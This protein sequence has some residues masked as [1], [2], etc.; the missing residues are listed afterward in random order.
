M[1]LFRGEDG[2]LL[3]VGKSRNLR[4]RVLAHFSASH[5]SSKESKLAQQV[6]DVE[7]IETG[8]ELGALLAESRLVKELAPAANRRLRKPKGVHCIRL[9]DSEGR[10]KPCVEPFGLDDLESGADSYGPFRTERDAL[11]A[12]EGKA[13]E[14]GLCLKVM[15][16]ESG[17]G[18]CFALQLGRCRGACVGTESP[19]LHDAR[20]RLALASL[21]IRSWPFPGP[22]GIREPVPNGPGTL[23]HVVDRWQHL[24]TAR[25]DTEVAELVQAATRT[26]FDPDAYRIVARCLDR[27]ASRDLVM[28]GAGER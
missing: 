23:L 3:Y 19:A 12:L 1:Y 13:R 10:L 18:S 8:G 26:A 17:P 9:R 14:A 16:L 24:G 27:I 20:L 28:L 22:I 6:R 21:R 7:W 2:A 4:S 15:G 11:R 5:R 25:D